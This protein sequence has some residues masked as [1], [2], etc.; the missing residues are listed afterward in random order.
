VL[1][2]VLFPDVRPAPPKRIRVGGRIQ[3]ARALH[4]VAPVYPMEALEQGISG[5]VRLEAIIAADGSIKQLRTIKGDPLLVE[6]A[7]VAIL[8]WRYRPTRLNGEAVE[9]LTSIEVNFKLTIE[10]DEDARPVEK[11]REGSR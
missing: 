6:A 10:P 4:K 8:Q 11:K 2:G 9:V 5:T 3:A 1:G 7:R